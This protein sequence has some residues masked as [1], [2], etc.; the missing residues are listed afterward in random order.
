MYDLNIVDRFPRLLQTGDAELTQVTLD[1]IFNLSFD[2]RLR[3]QMIQIGMLP[4]LVT[5]LSDTN[6]HEVV[7]VHRICAAGHRYAHTEF[8]S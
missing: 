6:H 7:H 8:E 5:F 4:K 1:L 3:A 2:G